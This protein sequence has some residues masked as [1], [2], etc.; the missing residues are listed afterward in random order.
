MQGTVDTRIPYLTTLSYLQTQNLN[1]A[2]ARSQESLSTSIEHIST[3]LRV[4]DASDDLA[5]FAIADRFDV[6]IQGMSKA[7]QNTNE[8]LS[9]ARIAENSLTEYV[10]IL[11]YMKE[12][13]TKA[14]NSSTTNNERVTLQEE[15]THLQD[16]L[17][18]ISEE[19]SFRGRKLLDGTYRTQNIQ[20]G[21]TLEQIM[22]VSLKTA[23]PD[24]VGLHE[25]VSEGEMNEAVKGVLYVGLNNGVSTSDSFTLQGYQGAEFIEIDDYASAKEIADAVNA[26]SDITG[27]E[28]KAGTYAKIYNLTR[29]GEIS[30]TLH[31]ASEVPVNATIESTSDLSPL[32]EELESKSVA[33][34]ISAT[35][36]ADHSSIYLHSD[37]GFNIG[38]ED[39]EN[40]SFNFP[41]LTVMQ[42]IGL[43]P[44]SQTTIGANQALV[45]DGF[46]GSALVGGYVEFQSSEPFF[47][48]T[49]DSA[50]NGALFTTPNATYLP[51]LKAV[52]TI[53]ISSQNSAKESLEILDKASGYIK[54][55]RSDVQ[56][57]ESGFE[58]I[59][60]R[61]ESASV[62]MEK[63]KHRVIDSDLASETMKA[64]SATIQIQSQNALIT[65]ANRLIPEYSLFLL[66]Q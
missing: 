66:R 57:Y 59:I 53:D 27:V 32:Y 39:F 14:T 13:A 7:L 38:I 16:R 11:E 62:Q 26:K 24:Q 35:L 65:Q 33:S 37:E 51:T 23:R 44:D 34:N 4:I 40:L 17:K 56:A 60:E 19:T 41:N 5:G 15:I 8:A 6:H 58:A 12:L 30:F 2:N 50:S 52:D 20:V 29:T 9:S 22:S 43:E 25:V 1:Q 61:L 49:M 47:L 54:N 28:A 42:F 3:G 21:A 64:S 45:D 36:S 18:D 48:F 46:M 10:D 63:S 31:G 55:I